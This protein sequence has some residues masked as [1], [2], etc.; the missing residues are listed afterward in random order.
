MKKSFICTTA[1]LLV[2]VTGPLAAHPVHDEVASFAY[3]LVHPLGDWG[4]LL[5]VIAIGLW[6]GW[7]QAKLSPVDLLS[8]V[9]IALF[10]AVN[11]YLHAM[12]MTQF[13]WMYAAG[14]LF[15]TAVTLAA[16]VLVAAELKPQIS[17]AV[18]IASE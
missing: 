18:S 7:R 5:S 11:G 15:S 4:H 1:T 3:G 2:I 8:W 17:P 12:A 9:V 14:M 10:L 16:G 13:T 6:A